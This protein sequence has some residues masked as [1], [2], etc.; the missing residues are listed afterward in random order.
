M[1]AR[2]RVLIGGGGLAGLAAGKRLIDAGYDVEILEKR[3]ALGGKWSSW[4]DK[5]GE[6]LETGLHVFFGAYDEIFTLMRELG[7]YDRILWKEHVLTY[8]LDEGDRFDFRT[9]KLPSPLHLLPSLIQ[10]R[11]FNWPQKLSLAK[12]LIPMLFG[13]D[14]Y[15]SRM[16]NISY[17]Q[18]HLQHGISDKLLKKMFVPLSLALKFVA[19]KDISAKIVL[20]VSGLFL[21]QNDASKMGFLKGS[22]DTHLMVP[23]ADYIRARGGTITTNAKIMSIETDETGRITGLCVQRGNG[24]PQTMTADEYVMALP[25]HNLKR[26]IP[27]QWTQHPYFDGLT[28]IDGVPVVSVHLWADRQ[29]SYVDNI[30]F[31]PDGVIPVYADMANTT[32]EYRTN[33]NGTMASRKSRFQFVVAPAHDLIHADDEE[34]IDQVWDSIQRNFPK[35]AKDAKI[36]KYHI[37]RVPQSVYWP[38]PGTD[39]YRVPQQSPID[40]LYLAGGYTIQRFYDSME[41]AVRSGNR[42]ASA[43]IAKNRGEA[44]QV[45]P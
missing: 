35:T 30:L 14:E 8:T 23:L 26:L 45:T 10:N 42:A 16:D 21:R 9:A 39:K 33:G 6:W 34:I 5:D 20:D 28:K 40:N 3:D 27:Q 1:E 18:W 32:P 19:P 15:Y 13:G 43:V 11:Y 17:Q 29:I 36:E 31:S 25:I 38:K 37:V 22:P 41:G 44:W 7:I 4:Q 24:A 12:N 2:K